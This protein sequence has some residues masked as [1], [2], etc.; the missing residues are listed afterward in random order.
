MRH[1]AHLTP[2]AMLN[3]LE[4]LGTKI[5]GE[6]Q[7]DMILHSLPNSFNQLRLNELM[8]KNEYTLAKFMNELITAE[9]S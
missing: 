7:V 4:V 5:D 9:N 2:L 1:L 8:N 6:S 3:T